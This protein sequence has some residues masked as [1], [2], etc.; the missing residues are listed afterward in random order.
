MSWLRTVAPEEARGRLARLYESAV[1]RAGRVFQ[2]VQAMSLRPR[3]LELSMG[4]YSG[5][6]HGPAG[7]SRRQREM[8]AVVVSSANGCHY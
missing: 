3:T 7:L 2:I 6:M 8:L 5:L 1:A 4:L